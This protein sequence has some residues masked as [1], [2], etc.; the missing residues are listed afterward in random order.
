MAPNHRLYHRTD[1]R[2]QET[3]VMLCWFPATMV[4]CH[5]QKYRLTVV[6]S[7]CVKEK[8]CPCYFPPPPN[9]PARITPRS[10]LGSWRVSYAKY[11]CWAVRALSQAYPSQNYRFFRP[12]CSYC[13]LKQVNPPTFSLP[14]NNPPSLSQCLYCCWGWG[15]FA[16]LLPRTR[17]PRVVFVAWS[18]YMATCA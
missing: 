1:H 13:Y 3:P 15:Y 16:F 17:R 14:P 12:S 5:L 2:F 18:L 10:R 11:Y 7:D 4:C 8:N 6:R 9:S